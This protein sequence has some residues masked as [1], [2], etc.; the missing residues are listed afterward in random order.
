MRARHKTDE[1]RGMLLLEYTQPTFGA[2]TRDE[3][4]TQDSPTIAVWCQ[5]PSRLSSLILEREA[6]YTE[7]GS[8]NAQTATPETGC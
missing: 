4:S 6:C 2:D 3:Q 7:M 5:W 1:P 8:Y